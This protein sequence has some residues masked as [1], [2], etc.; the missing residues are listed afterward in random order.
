LKNIK[1]EEAS[2]TT[3]SAK[4]YKILLLATSVKMHFFI[5][6]SYSAT[7]IMRLSCSKYYYVSNLLFRS[8]E[9]LQHQAQ[10]VHQFSC[11][12]AYTAGKGLTNTWSSLQFAFPLR[13]WLPQVVE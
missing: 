4:K 1:N 12:W 13:K 9:R 6:L 7:E 2:Q 5:Q 3:D 8:Y 10:R 11:P